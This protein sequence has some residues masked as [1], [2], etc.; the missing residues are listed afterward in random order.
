[1]GRQGL[2]FP[3]SNFW[4]TEALWVGLSIAR[5]LISCAL[6]IGWSGGARYNGIIESFAGGGPAN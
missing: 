3:E 6:H 2:H 1:M 5:G 4:S